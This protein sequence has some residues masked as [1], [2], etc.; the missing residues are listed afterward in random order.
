[1]LADLVFFINLNCNICGPIFK[2]RENRKMLP[3]EHLIGCQCVKLF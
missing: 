2:H 3:F 1:M